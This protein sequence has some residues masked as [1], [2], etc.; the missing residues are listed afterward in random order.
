M[1]GHTELLTLRMKFECAFF[2]A[3][4]VEF[5][6][7]LRKCIMAVENVIFAIKK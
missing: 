6:M 7:I 5:I 1:C 2:R 3:S 4:K